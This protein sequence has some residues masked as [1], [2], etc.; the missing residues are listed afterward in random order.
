[1]IDLSIGQRKVFAV[2]AGGFIFT[3]L[4]AILLSSGGRY[5]ISQSILEATGLA[6]Y[7]GLVSTYG[8]AAL[9]AGLALGY[10]V[11]VSKTDAERSGLDE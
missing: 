7:Q 4:F 6:M 3:G 10:V 1:M 8:L 11:S 5:G 2:L 9:A